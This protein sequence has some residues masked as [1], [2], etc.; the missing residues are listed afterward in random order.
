MITTP[1]REVGRVIVPCGGR[2]TRML[3]LTHGAPKELLPIGGTPILQHVLR[4]CAHSGIASV[5]IV[6]SPE[7]TAIVDFARPLAGRAGMPQSIEFAVQQEPRGLADAIRCGASFAAGDPFAVAL[8]DNLFVGGE[9]AV[10][11]VIAAF[12]ATGE[13][14][15]GVTEL[16]ASD[17]ARRGPTPVYPGEREGDLFRI[18]RVPD[19]GAHEATFDTRGHASAVTGV[20]R[21]VFTEE[22]FGVIDAAERSLATGAELDDIPVLQALL[23]RGRLI[24]CMLSGR[25]VDVGIPQGYAEAVGAPELFIS[26]AD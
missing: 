2:G 21:Y 11:E 13:N 24:G 17:A 7:K 26:A 12:A 3:P 14:V 15:V 25:F 9:P 1:V 20:G 10:A 22:V 5:L 18:E 4:E 19:K 23:A 8:P 16:F 6:V